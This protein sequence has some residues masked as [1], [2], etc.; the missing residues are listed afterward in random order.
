MS[1]NTET[2]VSETDSQLATEAVTTELQGG[3]GENPSAESATTDAGSSTTEESSDDAG[4]TTGDASGESS[5][6]TVPAAE[7]SPSEAGSVSADGSQ[8]G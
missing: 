3:N 2:L 5:T 1:E 4:A 6:D 7:G 8:P